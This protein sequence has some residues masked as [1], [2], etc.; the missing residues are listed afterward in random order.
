MYT[1]ISKKQVY[2]IGKVSDLLEVLEDLSNTYTTVQ[3]YID[4]QLEPQ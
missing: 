1:I 3:S 2:F 4:A